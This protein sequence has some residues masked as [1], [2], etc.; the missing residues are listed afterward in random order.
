MS[1][2]NC[3]G[4]EAAIGRKIL[5]G[6]SMRILN[7]GKVRMSRFKRVIYTNYYKQ[8]EVGE[9]NKEYT[10]SRLGILFTYKL[11]GKK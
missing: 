1:N 2:G 5:N 8:K 7:W 4:M 11:T 9:G 6:K 10:L 3:E